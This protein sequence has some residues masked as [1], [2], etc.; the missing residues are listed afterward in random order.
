MKETTFQDMDL[1]KEI[2]TSLEKMKVTRPTTVQQLAIPILMK[3]ECLIA[4][5][6]TGPGN[7]C[8]CYGR[9]WWARKLYSRSR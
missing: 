8:C 2:L 3:D 6:P 5:A 9:K 1:S 7:M 4:K